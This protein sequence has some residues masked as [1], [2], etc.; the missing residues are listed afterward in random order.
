LIRLDSW[1]SLERPRDAITQLLGAGQRDSQYIAPSARQRRVT[2]VC[3]RRTCRGC[4]KNFAKQPH[5]KNIFRD[6]LLAKA[7]P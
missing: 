7:S 4:Q 3:I 1:R 5:A 6:D 2:P